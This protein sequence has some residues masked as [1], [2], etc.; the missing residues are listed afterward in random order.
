[1]RLCSARQ[2]EEQADRII[3][4]A[5]IQLLIVR[6]DCAVAVNRVL[7]LLRIEEVATKNRAIADSRAPMKCSLFRIA[8]VFTFSDQS[9]IFPM[10]TSSC[11]DMSPSSEHSRKTL[12][13]CFIH[14]SLARMEHIVIHDVRRIHQWNVIRNVV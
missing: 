6:S 11:N 3:E 4:N 14:I 1:M 2:L 9:D 8:I 5:V 7:N 10:S 13:R 12:R